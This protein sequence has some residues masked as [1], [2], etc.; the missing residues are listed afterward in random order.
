MPLASKPNGARQLIFR[1]ALQ[2]AMHDL[3]VDRIEA[4]GMNFDQD[5]AGARGRIGKLGNAHMIGDRAIT[6][7]N[8]GSHRSIL[9]GWRI[10]ATTR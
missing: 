3:D 2:I 8:E 4:G 1:D 6:V 5:V 9:R 7:E 10:L